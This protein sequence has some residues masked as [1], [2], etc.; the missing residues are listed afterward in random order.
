[1][2]DN[3]AAFSYTT[4]KDSL[5]N[6]DVAEISQPPYSSD[7]APADFSYS[8]SK[9]H[10][11]K[12]KKIPGSIGRKEEYNHSITCRFF[13]RLVMALLCNLKKDV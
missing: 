13:V 11:Q 8:L 4:A 12:N 10:T 3:A 5:P 9:N 2:H 1:L 6:R 7:L